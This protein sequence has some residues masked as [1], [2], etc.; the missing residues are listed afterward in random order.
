M[1]QKKELRETPV[2]TGQKRLSPFSTEPVQLCR[3]LKHGDIMP[4]NIKVKEGK[5]F[6]FYPLL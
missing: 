3:L 5:W 1:F 2:Y 6:Q 4:P